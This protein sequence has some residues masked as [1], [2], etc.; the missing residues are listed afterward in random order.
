MPS[1]RPRFSAAN[2]SLRS[3]SESGV[4]TAPPSPC[5][6]RAAISASVLGAS[7]AAADASV[8]IEPRREH[9]PAADPVTERAAVS[10]KTA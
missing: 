5:T 3:V 6:A 1:A 7:A 9:R 2:A 8:K 10:R 4:I